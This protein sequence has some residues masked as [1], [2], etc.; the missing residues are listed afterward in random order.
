MNNTNQVPVVIFVYKRLDTLKSVIE[1]LLKNQ[2]APTTDLIFISDGPKNSDES[3]LID[4]VRRYILD[5]KG[6]QSVKLELNEINL[7]L[8]NSF[9][10]GISEVFLNYEKAIFL[11]DDNYVSK[12]FLFYMSSALLK[13]ENVNNVGCISGFSYP[14]PFLKRKPYFLKG[15]ETWSFA[16]WR[17]VWNSFETDSVK[18]KSIIDKSNKKRVLNMYGFNFYKMLDMQIAKK[19]DSWGVR[20]W[21]NAVC[22]DLLCLYPAKPHCVNIGWGPDGTHMQSKTRILSS[23]S[24]LETDRELIWLNNARPSQLMHVYLRIYNAIE[25]FKSILY[26]TF[27][28]SNRKL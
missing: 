10:K 25:K 24:K 23:I 20:W 2:E 17:R 8:A 26:I 11:E 21:S 7:G 27:S 14:T 6:F 12:N 28:N 9:I 18:L 3:I 4:E 15:A 16:T 5:L 19:I 1:S 13:Y 22:Q